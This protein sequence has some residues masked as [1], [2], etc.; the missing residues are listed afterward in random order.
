MTQHNDIPLKLLI[1]SRCGRGKGAE[2]VSLAPSLARALILFGTLCDHTFLLGVQRKTVLS[3]NIPFI[4]I[5]GVPYYFEHSVRRC[6][7][8]CTK[9]SVSWLI[10]WAQNLGTLS[11]THTHT[12]H[13]Q[14]TDRHEYSQHYGGEQ[15]WRRHFAAFDGRCGR[16]GA[17]NARVLE[18]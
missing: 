18:C 1:N 6:C 11:C 15:H 7:C 3:S 2:M 12:A 4:C 16:S 8:C 13:E 9:S 10:G 5:D 14:Q 17:M